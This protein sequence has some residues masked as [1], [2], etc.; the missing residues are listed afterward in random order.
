MCVIGKVAESEK[1]ADFPGKVH[2]TRKVRW[3]FTDDGHADFVVK[4]SDRLT[5]FHGIFGYFV[6]EYVT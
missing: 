6:R 5:D 2:S 3:G 1:M 4:M